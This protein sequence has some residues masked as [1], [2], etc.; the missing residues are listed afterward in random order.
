MTQR[1]LISVIIPTCR[2]DAGI[3]RRA[4]VSALAQTHRDIELIVVDDS[5]ESFPGRDAVGDMLCSLQDERIRYIRHETNRGACAARNTGIAHSNGTYAAFLDD[6]DEWLPEKLARQLKRMREVGEDYALIGCGS[7]TV[8]DASG[9][10]RIRKPWPARGMVFDA[11]IL[12]NFIGSTSF[13]L[14]RRRCLDETGLF[15]VLMKSAQDYEMWLRLAARY[16]ADTEDEPLAL[17]H[18]N[19]G[20]RI[21]INE[22]NRIQGLERLNE[23]YA[24]YLREHPA[25]LSERLMKLVPHYIRAGERD[26]AR[27]AFFRAARLAPFAIPKNIPVLM[28]FLKRR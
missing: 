15:D 9:A 3:V 22:S 26:K 7:V 13:P 14:I 2:R 28:E 20:A 16:K 10:R 19:G 5:P 18:V 17:Y 27:R 23:I 1:E 4:V 11:L 21:S 12:K 6:D 25:A 8:D 24:G